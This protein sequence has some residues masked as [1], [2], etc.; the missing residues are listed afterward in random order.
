MADSEKFGV[1]RRSA[2]IWA[3]AAIHGEAARLA[4]I[5]DA[6]AS[7]LGPGDRLVYLGN[8]L[9]HGPD[10][11]GTVDELLRFR[12][13]VI[14]RPLMFASDVVYLRGRQ[15]EMWQKLQQL[16]F[17][18]NPREVLEWMLAHGVEATLAAYGADAR[19]GLAAAREGAVSITRWTNA[20]RAAVASRPGHREL[21]S[22]LKRAASTDDGQL[23]FVHAGVD[24]TRPLAAQADALW[25][26]APGFG[27]WSAP[28][29]GF[30]LVVRGYDPAGGGPAYQ[31]YGLTIDAGAGR[32]GPL[33]AVC[34]SPAGEILE[35]LQA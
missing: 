20:L 34:L 9:G 27:C 13:E 28:Y 19:K 1:L 22:A 8:Y 18:V 23:L 3:I 16:Q 4:A 7:R 10:V 12:R 6:I 26:G 24:V 5:H 21:M 33:L 25:W 30:R 14:A 15:E 31:P 32:G 29:D 2:R 17:A 11:I 35:Q